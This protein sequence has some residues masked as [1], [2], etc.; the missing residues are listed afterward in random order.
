MILYEAIRR[1]L[2]NTRVK[3]FNTVSIKFFDVIIR[4]NF[5]YRAQKMIHFTAAI[6][7]FYATRSSPR[8]ITQSTSAPVL[9]STVKRPPK[10]SVL[11]NFFHSAI[12]KFSNNCPTRLSRGSAQCVDHRIT[13][14]CI[15]KNRF[16]HLSYFTPTIFCIGRNSKND[17]TLFKNRDIPFYCAC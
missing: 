4:V 1:L 16:W 3:L 12:K 5:R 13:K 17:K 9:F 15:P 8:A 14:P 6:F 7:D 2:E 10:V 11:F